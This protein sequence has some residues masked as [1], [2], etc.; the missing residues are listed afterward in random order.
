M[1][2]KMQH[3]VFNLPPMEHEA[4]SIHYIEKIFIAQFIFMTRPPLIIETGTFKGQTTKFI[5]QFLAQN[6]IKGKI[7][8]FDLPEVIDTLLN[9]DGYFRN[10]PNVDLVKGSLPQTLSNYLSELNDKIS[11]AIID[12]EHSYRQVY[13]ELQTIDPYMADNGYIFCHDYLPENALYAGVVKAVDTFAKDHNY[14][15][16]PVVGHG[17]WGAAVLTK[18][19]IAE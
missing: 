17:V 5:S 18:T 12:S 19:R 8:S 6:G 2:T 11:F 16:L 10:A 9:N 13:S 7:A 3:E 15:M 4:G 14:N 1:E